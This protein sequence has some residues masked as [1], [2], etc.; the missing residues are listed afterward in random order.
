[1][2]ACYYSIIERAEDGHFWG[3]VPDLPG[4]TADGLTEQEVLDRLVRGVRECL[5]DL[6]V[7]G[8]PVPQ[9]SPAEALPRRDGA[10]ELRR[11]LLIIS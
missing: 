3:W 6:I 1:M 8:Q 2:D 9:P 11:L 10:R 5:R 7:T 4:V